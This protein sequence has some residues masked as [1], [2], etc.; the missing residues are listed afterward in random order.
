MDGHMSPFKIAF[1]LTTTVASA[2]A[3]E[4]GTLK[5]PVKAV[6]IT[7]LF[8]ESRG[9][10]FHAGIDFSTEQPVWAAAA[11]EVVFCRDTARDGGRVLLGPGNFAVLEHAENLRSYYYH[12]A[13]GSVTRPLDRV[14]TEQI[15]GMMG[16]TG[17]STANHLHFM[18]EDRKAGRILNPLA[19]L[20][21]VKDT[22][23]PEVASLLLM[24][25]DNK[26]Q[27]L[28][29]GRVL[30]LRGEMKLFAI[31]W[32]LRYDMMGDWHRRPNAFNGAGVR[33]LSWKVDDR[34]IRV[35]DFTYLKKSP[36]GFVVEGDFTHDDVYGLPWNFRLGSFLP[37][38]PMH[39]FQVSA[40]DWA[41]NADT[42]RARLLFR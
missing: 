11:G 1:L 3:Y 41:G 14:S 15:L 40:E 20:P 27:P 34:L 39:D 2:L 22:R 9:D 13:T 17:R 18:V 23:N 26:P 29:D 30:S 28:R 5:F 21:P 6:H 38:Q 7:S 31:A 35:Y 25:R 33:R 4:E 36:R 42:F 10:H 8:G 16:S 37:I 19:V 24:G 12:L 32:D